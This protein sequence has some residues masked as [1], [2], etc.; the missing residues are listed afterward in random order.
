MGHKRRHNETAWAI[1]RFDKFQFA[2]ASD[3]EVAIAVKEVVFSQELADA[4]VRRLNRVNAE[5][6]CLY[7]WVPTR[8]L[9]LGTH[10]GEKLAF[11]V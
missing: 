8:I 7:W 2:D 3:I 4:E 9:R 1:V 6:Q 5:K 10:R 11:P